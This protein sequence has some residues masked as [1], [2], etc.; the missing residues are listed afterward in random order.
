MISSYCLSVPLPCTQGL[1][2]LLN[3]AVELESSFSLWSTDLH[4]KD[5]HFYLAKHSYDGNHTHLNYGIQILK[6]FQPPTYIC[7]ILGSTDIFE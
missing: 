6:K 7:I 4:E 5:M 2:S 1:H 3:L